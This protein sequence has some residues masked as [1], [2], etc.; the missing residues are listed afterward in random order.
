VQNKR[1]S[2]NPETPVADATEP[3]GIWRGFVLKLGEEI[4]RELARRA[5]QQP[6]EPAQGVLDRNAATSA[7]SD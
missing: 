3:L 2:K 6:Q 7:S 4:G 1:R 5:K